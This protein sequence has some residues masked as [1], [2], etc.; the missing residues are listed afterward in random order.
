MEQMCVLAKA[1]HWGSAELD[2]VMNK[3]KKTIN[4]ST[5]NIHGCSWARLIEISAEYVE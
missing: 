1:L 2:Q 5:S 3:K 4:F